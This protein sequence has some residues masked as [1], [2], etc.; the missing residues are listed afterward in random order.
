MNEKSIS[1][2]I[3]AVPSTASSSS[4]SSSSSSGTAISTTSTNLHNPI[5]IT[6]ITDITTHLHNLS[7]LE[8]LPQILREGI[9]FAGAGAALLLQAAY[10]G[11]RS[12][13]PTTEHES[14]NSLAHHLTQNL[15][16]TLQQ[17]AILVFGTSHEKATLLTQLHPPTTTTTT[18]SATLKT[19]PPKTTRPQTLLW[20]AA[21]LYTTATDLYQRTYGAVDYRT[22]ERA[23]TEFTLVLQA[24]TLGA[25]WPAT[26]RG[27][28]AYWDGQM[29]RLAVTADAH[30][31]ARAV[32]HQSTLVADR[33]PR[34][35]AGVMK[36]VF[37]GVTIELLP[38][39]VRDAYGLRSSARTRGWYRGLMAGFGGAVYPALP[40][41]VRG[42]PLRAC[43]GERRGRREGGG[44]V[45]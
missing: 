14:S 35:M 26:R 20:L 18:S 21:T 39:R 12:V 5:T 45:G 4:S 36:P 27:F 29:A 33:C 6:D 37:R 24:L 38:P 10:P 11:I 34:W 8:I 32:L 13:F 43:L 30:R 2:H 19:P 22:A 40:G 25:L 41:W 3:F 31:V 23:Y 17:I 16:T 15:Q 1:E 7:N 28:W 44:V 9:L 42:Y